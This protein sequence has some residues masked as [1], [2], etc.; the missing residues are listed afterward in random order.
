[1]YVTV[2]DHCHWPRA[3]NPELLHLFPNIISCSASLYAKTNM[4]HLYTRDHRVIEMLGK[5]HNL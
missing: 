1:V 5:L 4:Y 2:R 3:V